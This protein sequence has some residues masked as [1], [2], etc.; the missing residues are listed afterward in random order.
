L[1]RSTNVANASHVD[2]SRAMTVYV[3]SPKKPQPSR[4]RIL[5]TYPPAKWPEP[6]FRGSLEDVRLDLAR[7]DEFRVGYRSVPRTDP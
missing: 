1:L 7:A 3:D 5:A 4:G 2:S 6:V